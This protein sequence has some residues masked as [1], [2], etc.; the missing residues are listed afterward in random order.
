MALPPGITPKTV[1]VGIASFFDGSIAEGRATITAPVNVVHGPSNRPI[2]SSDMSK[3]FV[4]GEASFDLCPTDAAGLNRVDW[5][6]KLKVEISGA[7]V[8]PDPI[9]FVLPEAGPDQIDLDALVPV[10]STAGTPISVEVL[11]A[12]SLDPYTASFLADPTSETRATL[13]SL[14]LGGGLDDAG[15]AALVGD[16]GTATGT[17]LRAAFGSEVSVAAYGAKAD[18][19]TDDT[20]AI[21]A[22]VADAAAQAALIGSTVPV[23]LM[24]GT[25]LVH[26]RP[27]AADA[28]IYAAIELPSNV[29]L[30]GAGRGATVVKLDA[31]ETAVGGHIVHNAGLG[32]GDSGISVSDLTVDGN[33]DNQT[34]LNQGVSFLRATDIA[35]TRVTVRNVFGDAAY[36]PGETFHFAVDS[37]VRVT[38][39]DCQAIGTAGEQGSGFGDNS[40]TDVQYGGCMAVGMSAGMG[41]ASWHGSAVSYTG[42]R[43]QQCGANGFNVEFGRDVL[44]AG[45]YRRRRGIRPGSRVHVPQRRDSWQRRIGVRDQRNASRGALRLRVPEQRDRPVGGHWRR[46]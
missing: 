28:G 32:G 35:V 6:Y 24:A 9:Y 13:D 40:S 1:T 42:C 44:Y 45:M 12:D 3:P 39:T 19:E 33:G 16:T 37:C 21:A 14:D 22:A 26:L 43:A 41:F 27:Q 29:H 18:G 25:H 7:K 15:V 46:Y 20:A 30:I 11:T 4:D 31:G 5:T 10:P 36:P 38:Y 17:A 2:F 8:Q 23:R 34:Q